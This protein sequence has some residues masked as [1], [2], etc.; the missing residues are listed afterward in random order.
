M[1]KFTCKQCGKE[2]TL[3]DSEIRFYKGKNLKLPK[4]CK[5][6][7]VK[8]KQVKG[9]HKQY[10]ETGPR[11]AP[12]HE[13]DINQKTS[14]DGYNK[15]M[16]EWKRAKRLVFGTIAAVVLLCIAAAVLVQYDWFLPK[17]MMMCTI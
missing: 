5:E 6:C 16:K 8:N 11:Q 7:R 15:D 14:N 2:F 13:R 10:Q 17:I 1:V 12:N 4:R 9:E 3:S